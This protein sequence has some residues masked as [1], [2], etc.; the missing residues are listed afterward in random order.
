MSD[1]ETSGKIWD[2][3]TKYYIPTFSHAENKIRSNELEISI[4]KMAQLNEQT[5]EERKQFLAEREQ[6][7]NVIVK[8][9]LEEH[10]TQVQYPTL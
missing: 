1:A 8:K 10:Q 3:R 5:E 6:K 4:K 9:P 2:Y 7:K